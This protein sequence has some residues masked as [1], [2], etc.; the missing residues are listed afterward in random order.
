MGCARICRNV[1]YIHIVMCTCKGCTY[2][3]VYSYQMHIIAYEEVHIIKLHMWC[4]CKH[5]LLAY[6]CIF[7]AYNL[8]TCPYY[9]I[10]NANI[11]MHLHTS[12]VFIH[13][14]CI[15]LH[16]IPYICIIVIIECICLHMLAYL[17][18]MFAYVL[19]IYVYVCIFQHMPC[20]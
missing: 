7:A 17:M 5:L 3:H 20:I 16:M 13:F 18:H 11:R 14:Y 19:H 9:W 12:C 2:M 6:D 8:H 15:F 1:H 4:T 10:H